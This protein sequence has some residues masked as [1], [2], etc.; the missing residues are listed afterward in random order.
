MIL[1]RAAVPL[2]SV[3]PCLHNGLLPAERKLFA[4]VIASVPAW[5]RRL[6]VGKWAFSSGN[7]PSFYVSCRFRFQVDSR[8]RFQCVPCFAP[9]SSA[10]RTPLVQ[11]NSNGENAHRDGR[12]HK[13]CSG[14]GRESSS[15]GEGSNDSGDSRNSDCSKGALGI[16]THGVSA[17][18]SRPPSLTRSEEL[19]VLPEL[20][21]TNVLVPLSKV[22]L[23]HLRPLSPQLQLQ[24][25]AFECPACKCSGLQKVR[26]AGRIVEQGAGA[27]QGLGARAGSEAGWTC[28]PRWPR[29][30]AATL[31]D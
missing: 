14:R 16:A 17:P 22:S 30:L 19:L 11:T 13:S 29:G 1:V 24:G 27:T 8:L 23:F 12:G 31:V 25:T 18:A 6:E 2:A 10:N 28:W 9:L 7:L 4:H 26:K 5:S 20:S 15:G 21:R 3:W